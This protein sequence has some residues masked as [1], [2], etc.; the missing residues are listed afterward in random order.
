MEFF[1]AIYIIL[2]YLC[3]DNPK[4]VCQFSMSHCHVCIEK[5]WLD[6]TIHLH[7]SVYKHHTSGTLQHHYRSPQVVSHVLGS[8]L[9]WL[10]LPFLIM[11]TY[12]FHISLTAVFKAKRKGLQLLLSCFSQWTTSQDE[13]D[14]SIKEHDLILQSHLF[15]WIFCFHK[16]SWY[17]YSSKYLQSHDPVERQNQ[18]SATFLAQLDLL[19]A[20]A[21]SCL[22]INTAAIRSSCPMYCII[23]FIFTLCFILSFPSLF[24]QL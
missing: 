2:S 16:N 3:I 19:N 9:L 11:D 24:I 14:P 4:Q 23:I 1:F 20:F 13:S 15:Q 18:V 5:N 17:T 8:V 10:N 12:F 22:S 6:C 7:G 21:T